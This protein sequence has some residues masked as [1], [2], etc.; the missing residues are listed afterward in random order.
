M[1]AEF[2]FQSAKIQVRSKSKEIQVRSK[3]WLQTAKFAKKE[4]YILGKGASIKLLQK[5]ISLAVRSE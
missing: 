3:T 2:S 1:H 4:G 5:K